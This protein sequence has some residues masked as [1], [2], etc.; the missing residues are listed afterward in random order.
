[1]DVRH[2]IGEL[3]GLLEQTIREEDL[4]L[5]IQKGLPALREAFPTQRDLFAPGDI[6]FLQSLKPISGHLQAF[7]ALREKLAKSASVEEYEPA[8]KELAPIK[9]AL[10]RFPVGKRVTA[11]IRQLHEKLQPGRCARIDKLNQRPPQ[12]KHG[13]AMMVRE[14][15][16][17]YFWGCSNYPFCEET[18][19][20]SAQQKDYLSAARAPVSTPVD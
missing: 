9:E 4:L 7:I 16:R 2:A 13:H 19:E 15:R 6:E 1:M 20:L 11:E 17:G 10:V 18:A 5:G 14:G 12:C 3:R 8:L